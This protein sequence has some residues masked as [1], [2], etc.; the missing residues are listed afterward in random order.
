M[1]SAKKHIMLKQEEEKDQQSPSATTTAA[2][3][4]PHTAPAS[5]LHDHAQVLQ[6]AASALKSLHD[7]ESSAS[8][9]N[10]PSSSKR[11]SAVVVAGNSA[12]EPSSTGGALQ[13]AVEAAF[14]ST[15]SAASSKKTKTTSGGS[16]PKKRKQIESAAG[17]AE[18]PANANTEPA[19]QF[20]EEIPLTFPQRLMELLD[21]ARN[22]DII[23]WLPHGRGFL[24]YQKRRF[25]ADIM[26][27]YFKQSKFTSFTASSTGGDSPASAAG[28]RPGRT[29][30]PTS[31]EVTSGCVC[32]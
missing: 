5:Q 21:D 17:N 9:S 31:A 18:D 11:A 6:E 30:I 15:L 13:A 29:T 22:D 24:I 14:A 27:K 2:A 4:A 26:P 28:R 25:A 1:A 10:S 8:D 16:N 19:S 3:A 7:G 20:D 12:A 32:R 23:G